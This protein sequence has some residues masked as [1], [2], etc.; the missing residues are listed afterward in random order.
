MPYTSLEALYDIFLQYPQVQ[1]DTRKLQA[2]DLYFALKGGNFDGNLFA[3]QALDAGAAFAI[4]DDPNQAT[5]DN[6]LLVSNVL[7]TLQ[8]LAA[9]HRQRSKAIIIGITGTNGKTTTKEIMAAVLSQKY[10]IIYT[11]GNLNNHIGVPLTLLTIKDDTEI[12]IIEMGANHVGEIASYCTWAMPDYGVITNIGKAHLE[13]FGSLEG[14]KQ[15]KSELYKAV[16]TYGKML[17]RYTDTPYL[18]ELTPENIP[19]KTFGTKQS[20]LI[21][22]VL[23]DHLTLQVAVRQPDHLKGTYISNLVGNYNLPNILCAL[24]VGDYFH[25]EAAA[26]QAAIQAYVPANHRSQLVHKG[27]NTIIMDAYNA[28]PSSMH[29]AITN[30]SKIQGTNKWLLLGAMKELG[31][32]SSQEHAKVIELVSSLGFENVFL[33]GQEYKD[34]SMAYTRFDSSEALRQYIAAHPIEDATILIKG[35]RGSAME[36]VLDAL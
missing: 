31:D 35:S 22:N 8:S 13:G 21:G 32:N 33:V 14:V 18:K 29:L 28:N 16:A 10:N 2:G 27:S 7:E 23:G 5:H 30:M 1:T 15:A 26:M 34:I 20:D 36:V 4:V 6:I 17:F 24:A 11:Q 19:V 3:Q 9:M 25:V 12:A